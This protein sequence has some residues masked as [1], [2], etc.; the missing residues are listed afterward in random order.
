MTEEAQFSNYIAI[1]LKARDAG[2]AEAHNHAATM[3]E[4]TLPQGKP[5]ESH[6]WKSVE[7]GLLARN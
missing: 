7:Y 5:N 3:A 4:E 2:G 1:G 6:F